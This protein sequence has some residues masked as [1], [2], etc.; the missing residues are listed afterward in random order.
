MT[1]CGRFIN[2]VWPGAITSAAIAGEVVVYFS[3]K[4]E[5]LLSAFLNGAR[6][7]FPTCSQHRPFNAECHAENTIFSVF[8][9]TQL[10]IKPSFI[11]PDIDVPSAHTIGLNLRN[12]I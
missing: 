12:L 8:Y 4:G 2:N 1:A 3:K 5:I 6:S 11:A 10:G 7:N 9:L